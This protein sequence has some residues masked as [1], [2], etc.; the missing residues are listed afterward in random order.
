MR[1]ELWAGIM[2]EI[3]HVHSVHSSFFQ[4]KVI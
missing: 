3:I 2:V 1:P 4:E